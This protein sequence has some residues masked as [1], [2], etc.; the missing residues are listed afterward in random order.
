MTLATAKAYAVSNWKLDESSGDAIDSVSINDL[1][2]SHTTTGAGAG[3]YFGNARDLEAD[4]D[5]Y[6]SIESNDE[7][8]G[9][10]ELD[11]CLRGWIKFESLGDH[12]TF[13]GKWDGSNNGYL[14]MYDVIGDRFRWFI[15]QIS[16]GAT[17]VQ[18][19]NFGS[20]SAGTW[21][22]IHCWWDTVSKEI[23]IS[24]NA[25]T[26]DTVSV[27][28]GFQDNGTIFQ[29]GQYAGG[30]NMD[31]LMSDVV[32]LKGHFL[33]S[34]ERTEDYNG[35]A[36]IA[37]EDWDAVAETAQPQNFGWINNPVNF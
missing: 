16:G 19:D 22:L 37:F 8:T 33:D 18:A 14:C 31:G 4:N 17:Y 6:F 9:A 29:L 5:D 3:L 11:L 24:I 27:G 34:S 28:G 25:G 21:Y 32:L 7:L 10:D 2:D 35:G 15:N 26:P 12:R 30:Q 1:T 20:P 23:G 36:G 13:G